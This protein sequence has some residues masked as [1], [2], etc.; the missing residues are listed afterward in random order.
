MVSEMIFSYCFFIQ[1]EPHMDWPGIKL[2]P[3]KWKAGYLLQP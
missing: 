2:G 1:Y 3:L